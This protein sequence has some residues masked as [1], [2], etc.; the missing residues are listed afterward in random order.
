[1]FSAVIS[2]GWKFVKLFEPP[3]DFNIS[4]KRQERKA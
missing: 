2:G 3:L 4:P 1:M